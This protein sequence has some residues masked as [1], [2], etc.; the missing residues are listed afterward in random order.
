MRVIG[1]SARGHRL[2]SPKGR[3]TRP[4]T[5]RVKAAIFSV[6]ET[7]G[8]APG[9][10]LDLYAGTGSLGIEALSRGAQACDFVERD[11]ASCAIIRDNLS[12]T[13]L[14]ERGRVHCMP[15]AKVV[16]RLV[17]P[18]DL[19]LMDPPFDDER[20]VQLL[21]R[22]AQSALVG[23][24]SIIVF[25]HSRRQRLP[26]RCGPFA[27]TQERRYGDSCVAIYR[28]SPEN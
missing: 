12:R 25:E 17:G 1:G 14:Q 22:L 20:A 16:E 11:F 5:D 10:V 7:L 8:A 26:E 3:R 18:Y 27:L 15:V 2:K 4:T 13:Q 6:L 23:P 28:H 9:R 19:V 24:Q 21:Q